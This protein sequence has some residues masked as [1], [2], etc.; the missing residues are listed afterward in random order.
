MID[1]KLNT[2]LNIGD[3]QGDRTLVAMGDDWP[4]QW[5]PWLEVLVDDYRSLASIA[6]E[7]EL[8]WGEEIFDDEESAAGAFVE[9]L[10]VYFDREFWEGDHISGIFVMGWI[11]TR[12]I[13][14]AKRKGELLIKKREKELIRGLRSMI[15]SDLKKTTDQYK[16]SAMAMHDPYELLEQI[17]QLENKLKQC[18]EEIKDKQNVITTALKEAQDIKDISQDCLLLASAILTNEPQRVVAGP[19]VLWDG[20]IFA[21]ITQGGV[22]LP[23]SLYLSLLRSLEKSRYPVVYVREETIKGRNPM[24]GTVFLLKGFEH[25]SD[26]KD[27]W[28]LS[29][30]VPRILVTDS[31]E[32]TKQAIAI[33]KTL[34]ATGKPHTK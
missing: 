13:R 34:S 25:I 22:S 10:G 18:S 29:L 14:S 2:D 6:I 8:D 31:P 24:S 11:D 17:E 12:S 21:L 16:L 4:D 1:S 27:I 28:Q 30:K 33:Y 20:T 9:E 5:E 26:W 32:M 23:E 15:I 7:A 19:L 3:R